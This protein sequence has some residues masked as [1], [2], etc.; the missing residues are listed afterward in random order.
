M[1]ESR[2][3][4]TGKKEDSAMVPQREAQLGSLFSVHLLQVSVLHMVLCKIMTYII[5]KLVMK[6]NFYNFFYKVYTN[7]LYP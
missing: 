6:A 7:D 3:Q 2:R 5:V 1:M 4:L